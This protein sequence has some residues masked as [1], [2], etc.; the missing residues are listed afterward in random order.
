MSWA[1]ES[2][3]MYVK[4]IVAGEDISPADARGAAEW[5]MKHR[6]SGQV[7]RAVVS[8]LRASL[9][10][11]ER[12]SVGDLTK[13][14]VRWK[15][16]SRK[17]RV[18]LMVV[19]IDLRRE[20]GAITEYIRKQVKGLIERHFSGLIEEVVKR[21]S[22][23]RRRDCE[24]G[25]VDLNGD[26]SGS[27]SRG[28]GKRST[29]V[30]REIGMVR[31]VGRIDDL[32][33][34]LLESAGKYYRGTLD[35][36]K[37]ATVVEH[38]ERVKRYILFERARRL[39]CRGEIE[40]LLVS[41]AFCQ[42]YFSQEDLW[43]LLKS[44]YPKIEELLLFNKSPE[45]EELFR[46]YSEYIVGRALGEGTFS[47]IKETSEMFSRFRLVDFRSIVEEKEARIIKER[48]R[49]VRDEVVGF[50][51]EMIAKGSPLSPE[52][53][54][55]LKFVLSLV[56]ESHNF[57]ILLSSAVADILMSRGLVESLEQIYASI[58]DVLPLRT[59]R[60]VRGILK[61]YKSASLISAEPEVSLLL[62]NSGQ[63]PCSVKIDTK[64]SGEMK[65]MKR[66]IEKTYLR[67]KMR[68]EWA[69]NLSTAEVEIGGYPCKM[70]LL[71]CFLVEMALEGEVDLGSVSGKEN[72]CGEEWETIRSEARL[73]L[74]CGLLEEKDGKI[75]F[76][77]ASGI[78]RT[79]LPP[80]LFSQ[81]R[82]D[83]NSARS[84]TPLYIDSYISRVLK[85][86]TRMKR[87][88]VYELLLGE[89]VSSRETI[90]RRIETLIKKGLVSE[91]QE[92]L[93]YIP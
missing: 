11:K 77:R 31:K 27:E 60:R 17:I 46:T 38:F 16:I 37:T 56:G 50:L 72:A 81:K 40:Q 23:E 92:S 4:S 83:S 87:E 24:E 41:I 18:N 84:T 33:R 88:E 53:V 64:R 62:L 12:L 3:S 22:E 25:S 9:P 30:R 51:S 69:D 14:Y 5:V 43:I 45:T 73:L 6:R 2:I 79:L 74:E 35:G 68:I 86:R 55:F 70:T 75:H 7:R 34:E 19:N 65:K 89:R 66:E 78:P 20:R 49:E 47:K 1:T 61:E 63:W 91:E 13:E 85:R 8:I 29:S 44:E 15:G 57:E 52:T 54:S 26:G 67:Q 21:V 90:E 36:K 48:E 10:S 58:E 76:G 93:V 71:Q 80:K 42:P 82:E 32:K 39:W 28:N 59:R